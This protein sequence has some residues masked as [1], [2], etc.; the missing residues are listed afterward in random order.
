[1]CVYQAFRHG[2]AARNQALNLMSDSEA[3]RQA[4]GALILAGGRSSRMGTDKASLPYRGA[5]L[6]MHMRDL[7]ACAGAAQ[8]LV[9]GPTGDLADTVPGAGPVS[10]LCA[11]ARQAVSRTSPERWLII[12][13]DMPRL[14]PRLLRRLVW[15]ESRAAYF[16]G[17][18]LPLA[19][20]LDETTRAALARA[21]AR[22][23]AGESIAVHQVLGL[24]DAKPLDVD[25]SELEQLVN[26][27]TPEEWAQ[28]ATRRDG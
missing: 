19:L 6:I 25:P 7:A 5:T 17:Q 24:L 23:K 15:A 9:S 8:V 26:A 14:E 2:R 27:N 3:S 13:V 4:F 21:E 10:G 28:I 12:P 1:M 18:P 16:S 11:L 22:L 20:A